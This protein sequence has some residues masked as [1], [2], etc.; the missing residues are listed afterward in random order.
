M[1]RSRMEFGGYLVLIDTWWNV[2]SDGSICSQFVIR[3]LIDTWWNV[4]TFKIYNS[5]VVVS[6]LID[7]WWNVNEILSVSVLVTH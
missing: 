4:N 7:T 3:V 1:Y 6:V 2:N 5:S